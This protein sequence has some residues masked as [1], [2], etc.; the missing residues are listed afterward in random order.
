MLFR[1]K[2][3][4]LPTRPLFLIPLT[5]LLLFFH[6]FL[7]PSLIRRTAKTQS[8]TRGGTLDV[9]I[10]VTAQH[11]RLLPLAFRPIPDR[12]WEHGPVIIIILDFPLSLFL[13]PSIAMTNENLGQSTP[14][15]LH[16]GKAPR[17]TCQ[18]TSN[19]VDDVR[20]RGVTPGPGRHLW[21]QRRAVR[22]QVPVRAP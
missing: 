15:G 9:F 2:T 14:S 16:F 5:F 1:R 13:L 19:S 17:A 8:Q 12:Q 11:F 7:H 20:A 4:C 3:K 21:E 10:V 6:S 18:I 22:P